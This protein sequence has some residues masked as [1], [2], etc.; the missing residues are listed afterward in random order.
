MSGIISLLKSLHIYG[1]A[2][3]LLMS[4]SI[5][6]YAMFKKKLFAIDQK[7]YWSKRA[8]DFAKELESTKDD[9]YYNLYNQTVIDKIQS[10]ENIGSILE[11]GCYYGQR[12]ALIKSA[13]PEK[14]IVGGDL[15]RDQLLIC[16]QHILTDNTIE[17]IN[18]NG[19]F[20]PFK[21]NSFDLIFTSGCLEHV[22]HDI[23]DKIFE[24]FKRVSKRNL[25]L[26]E[27]Y[28]KHQSLKRK[29]MYLSMNYFYMHNYE[30]L[31]SKQG[32]KKLEV[33]GIPD[34]NNH[35]R[36]SLFLYSK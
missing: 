14:S 11:V 4:I 27:A 10:L 34:E 20:L 30:K 23:I 21:D 25:L 31:L 32:F 5:M 2:K 15:G 24:E 17:L 13:F 28:L 19:A 33:F 3:L 26:V 35:R 36:Y 16:K 22:P 8:K 7:D 1:F 6:V 9:A 18:C 12:L 29:L